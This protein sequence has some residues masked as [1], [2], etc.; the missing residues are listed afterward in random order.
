MTYSDYRWIWIYDVV[1]QPTATLVATVTGDDDCKLSLRALVCLPPLSPAADRARARAAATADGR[2][3]RDPRHAAAPRTLPAGIVVAPPRARANR[4]VWEWEDRPPQLHCRFCENG[5]AV[6]GADLICACAC[7]H[8]ATTAPSHSR[9]AHE[10]CLGAFV[11]Q[12]RAQRATYRGAPGLDAYNDD[13]DEMEAAAAVLCSRCHAP[14]AAL[15]AAAEAGGA[16]AEGETLDEAVGWQSAVRLAAGTASGRLWVFTLHSGVFAPLR[17]DREARAAELRRNGATP[18]RARHLKRGAAPRFK[19]AREHFSREITFSAVP[20]RCPWQPGTQGNLVPGSASF[21]RL[22]SMRSHGKHPRETRASEVTAICAVGAP[23]GENVYGHAGD[24]LAAAH[25]DA[26]VNVWRISSGAVLHTLR[27]HTAPPRALCFAAHGG[28]SGRLFSA[29]DDGRLCEWAF[30]FVGVALRSAAPTIAGVG[31]GG[32]SPSSAPGSA[33][34]AAASSPPGPN[35]HVRCDTVTRLLTRRGAHKRRPVP[36]AI[37]TLA[38]LPG[39]GGIVAGCGDGSLR[40]WV[41]G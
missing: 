24:V 8:S 1:S 34:A 38:L 22:S 2:T 12:K 7:A 20:R 15:D 40:A 13:D 14:F 21:N 33:A 30:P 32:A 25:V 18:K 28:G 35:E 41:R 31:R 9:W 36:I 16:R 23:R 26:T 19:K 11:A 37:R 29:G 27:A 3:Y 6:G 17:R 4:A 5:Q 10:E 39:G